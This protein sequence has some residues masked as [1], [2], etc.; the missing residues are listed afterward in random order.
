M[1]PVHRDP[2]PIIASL[3]WA[4]E[5][6]RI[7]T[8]TARR[9]AKVGELPGAFQLDG[10]LWRVSIPVFRAE[11]ERRA[12]AR[13]APPLRPV[14]P[15]ERQSGPTVPDGPPEPSLVRRPRRSAS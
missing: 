1:S 7:S 10:T 14:A 9:L 13:A 2:E 6:L 12:R 11:I 4:A 5:Q 8:D 15:L 3:S